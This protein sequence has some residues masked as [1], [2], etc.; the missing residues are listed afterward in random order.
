MFFTRSGRTFPTFPRSILEQQTDTRFLAKKVFGL[1]KYVLRVF[2]HVVKMP[3]H[4]REY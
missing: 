2:I 1:E 4:T 3:C